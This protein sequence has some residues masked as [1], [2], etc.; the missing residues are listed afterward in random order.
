[1]STQQPTSVGTAQDFAKRLQGAIVSGD[2]AQARKIAEEAVQKGIDPLMLIKCGI[3]ESAS[4]V[5]RRFDTGEF[6][7]PD[8]VM[9]GDAMLAATEVLATALPQDKVQDKKVVVIG[10]VESDLHTIGKNIVAMML[11]ASGFSVYD[12]GYDVKSNV[13]ITRAKDLKADIIAVSSLLTTTMP[14]MRE[15]ID[16]LQAMKLRERFKVLVGGGPVT[17]EFAAE[18]GADGYGKDAVAAVQVA[19]DL[20]HLVG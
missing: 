13:F 17:A 2:A 12:L 3:G 20:L 5:G 10:T 9:A 1:M 4:E 16:D 6:F 7:L 11:R 19:R 14:Y 8:L 18:I 15:L